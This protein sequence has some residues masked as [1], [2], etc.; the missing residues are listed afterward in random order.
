MMRCVP[1]VFGL[2]ALTLAWLVGASAP[3]S[4]KFWGCKDETGKVLSQWTTDERGRRISGQNPYAQDYTARRK[5]PR[6]SYG[7]ERYWNGRR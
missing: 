1:G 4:A 3:A 2:L 5:A 6:A 7:N